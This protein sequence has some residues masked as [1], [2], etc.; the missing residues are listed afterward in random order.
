MKCPECGF[1]QKPREVCS[2][3]GLVLSDY[4]AKK[5]MQRDRPEPTAEQIKRGQMVSIRRGHK[6]IRNVNTRDLP[7]K[8]KRGEVYSS[9]EISSDEQKW[10]LAGKHPQLKTLFQKSE[11]PVESS[12]PE[13]KKQKE[14]QIEVR[15]PQKK[16]KLKRLTKRHE[17]GKM[18]DEDY[19]KE[20]NKILKKAMDEQ[21]EQATGQATR[22]TLVG[23]LGVLMLSIGIY[24]PIY[25]V[26]LVPDTTL[27]DKSIIQLAIMVSLVILTMLDMA[28]NDFRWARATGVVIAGTL[29]TIFYMQ[30]QEIAEVL[31][32][33]QEAIVGG[34]FDGFDKV[35]VEKIKPAW[36]WIVLS[37]GAL[38]VHL[39]GWLRS[40]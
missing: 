10:V 9:D 15:D 26:R 3:C 1:E 13:N 4:L 27:Y 8:I 6:I 21:R 30:N 24:L 18:S 14:P 33:K 36:G 5:A 17:S 31:S 12:P 35:G 39:S 37:L 16:A 23:G 29:F 40:K 28:R 2:V 34:L 11:E 7:E 32:G 22:A 19:T 20:R 38:M 25:S